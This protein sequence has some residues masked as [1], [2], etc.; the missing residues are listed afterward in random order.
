MSKN[1]LFWK[2]A[3]TP[4]AAC[5]AL[6]AYGQIEQLMRSRSAEET[7]YLAEFVIRVARRYLRRKNSGSRG[8]ET[9][10]GLTDHQQGMSKKQ[11]FLKYIP[12]YET[13]SESHQKQSEQ[14]LM[15]RIT[16]RKHAPRLRRN[17]RSLRR[18]DDK[19]C[20]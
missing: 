1:Q 13:M 10:Q 3:P 20:G 16:P 4:T 2:T 12:G 15:H 7:Q 6:T 18:I 19:S 17:G 5:A 8:E 9:R 14:A 11:L